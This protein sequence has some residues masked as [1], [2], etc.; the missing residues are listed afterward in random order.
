MGSGLAA[1][2]GSGA[3]AMDFGFLA[4]FGDGIGI[5]QFCKYYDGVSRS[6]DSDEMF[7]EMLKSA[8]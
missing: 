3:G 5:E 6:V 1:K 4:A 8:S 2:T 7:L